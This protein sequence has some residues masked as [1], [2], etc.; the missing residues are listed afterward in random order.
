MGEKFYNKGI[1]DANNLKN[2]RK[3]NISK[4]L[5]FYFIYVKI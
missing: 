1:W 5:L 4:F 2:Y 3:I